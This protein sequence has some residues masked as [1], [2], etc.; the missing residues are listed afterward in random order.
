[1][2][3]S[4]F[5][6]MIVRPPV[7]FEELRR[8][9]ELQLQALPLG[10]YGDQ[11][12]DDMLMKF[13]ATYVGKYQAERVGDGKILFTSEKTLVCTTGGML[14]QTLKLKR[15]LESEFGLIATW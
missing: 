8:G 1:M 11:I 7:S 10:G 15:V 6:A 3:D 2:N 14:S 4:T 12:S 5:T 13:N 9:Y